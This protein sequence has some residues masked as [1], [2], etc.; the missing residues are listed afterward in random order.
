MVEP[1]A[2]FCVMKL[3]IVVALKSGMTAIRVRPEALPRFSTATTTSAARRPLSWRLP[4]IPAWLPPPKCRRLLPRREAARAPHSP[5][6]AGACAVSSKRF[7]NAEDQAGAGEATPRRLA[8][9]SSSG[10]PPRTRGSAGSSYCEGLSPMS[11]RLGDDR[12]R[13]ASV[14]VPP[15]RNRDR[16][17]I[18]GTCSPR[19]S[20]KRPGT[21][22]RPLRGR[23]ES[24]TGEES[25]ERTDEALRDTTPSG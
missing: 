5:S 20:G 9:R 7:R 11:A 23:T 12:R 4:R 21:L 2:T 16:A 22:G 8:C 17:R 13:T 24:E 14:F 18:G 6:L 1:G 10:R 3:L 19:T 25:W 15:A